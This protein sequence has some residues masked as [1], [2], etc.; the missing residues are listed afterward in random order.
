MAT[1]ETLN[2]AA[3]AGPLR[4]RL[5]AVLLALIVAL[6]AIVSLSARDWATDDLAEALGGKA[7]Q[8]LTEAQR[9]LTNAWALGIPFDHEDVVHQGFDYFQRLLQDNP[10]VRF[11]AVADLDRTLF[12]YEGTNADRLT[13]LMATPDLA[14]YTGPEALARGGT[15]DRAVAVGD[16]SIRVAPLLDDG[17]AVAALYVGV[18]RRIA[19]RYF[20]PRLWVLGVGLLTL[21]ALAWLVVCFAVDRFW[22]EPATRLALRLSDARQDRWSIVNSR[23]EGG[24]FRDVARAMNLM[25]AALRDRHDDAVGL[26]EEIRTQALDPSVAEEAARIR[27]RFDEELPIA[28]P[29]GEVTAG[30][31]TQTA[32]QRFAATLCLA[33][34]GALLL[35]ILPVGAG[36]MVTAGI[37]LLAGGIASR[38]VATMILAALAAAV[39]AGSAFILPAL[40]GAAYALALA[41]GVAA[42]LPLAAGLAAV[43]RDG[44]APQGWPGQTVVA[45]VAGLAAG[46]TV[47]GL[48][49]VASL[50][51]AP[52]L[53]VAGGLL[54]GPALILLLVTVTGRR[55]REAEA[56][57]A[58]AG[59]APTAHPPPAQ[60]PSPD[61]SATELR[62]AA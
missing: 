21:V 3:V 33:I 9:V 40:P 60:P 10:E 7:Q 12:F 13:G 59:P 2:P 24:E 43:T 31:A 51:V 29:T 22:T 48:A 37:G 5:F 15:G 50:P 58:A 16:F 27:A 11:L 52:S 47:I 23:R 49:D 26:A 41:G 46:I 6:G 54:L 55:A 57:P 25:S 44:L 19:D 32:A 14:N 61:R 38:F 35:P 53:S 4:L 20:G 34:A 18:D 39:A 62:D 42:G 17:A 8:V 36:V 45:T 28:F 56:S 30:P 1:R